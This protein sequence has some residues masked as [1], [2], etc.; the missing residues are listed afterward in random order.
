M[1]QA[2]D[3]ADS[4]SAVSTGRRNMF[5]NGDM[6]IS[7]RYY[8]NAKT[9]VGN[10]EYVIDEWEGYFSNDGAVTIERVSTVPSGEGFKYS[11]KLSVATADTSLSAAQYAVFD[12]HIEAQNLKA[13]RYGT[14]SA[15]TTVLSFWV[16]SSKTGTY[17]LNFYY[18]DTGKQVSKSY[19]IDTADTWEKKTVTVPG[20][21]SN[22]I[23]H[24]H[25][26]GLRLSFWLDAGSNY[27]SGALRSTHTTFAETD[28]AVGQ[29]SWMDS[30]SNDF[31]ITGI[32]YELGN[33]ATEYE[34]QDYS[35]QL[36]RAQ[37]YFFSYGY[38]PY[39]NDTDGQTNFG[40]GMLYSDT[41]IHT[42]IIHPVNMRIE[43][44]L[45]FNTGTNYFIGYTDGTSDSFDSFTHE[46]TTSNVSSTE[47]YTVS[48]NG[49]SLAGKSGDGALV[50]LTKDLGYYG[51]SDH[52][53]IGFSAEL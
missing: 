48:G 22:S 40:M 20:N 26:M 11:M 28:R 17:C 23:T 50:R 36:A 16:R 7:Q 8:D 47:L 29:T 6:T 37:R 32:Q 2:R 14:A 15:K 49:F 35:E 41:Q 12:A 45:V 13:L 31:Y 51:Q 10:G 46:A 3:F 53:F 21:T 38:D 34:F 43:P 27:T 30:T 24:D 42:D 9:S 1:S 18:P 5:Y 39:D 19:T 52:G 33:V 25:G 44:S 4:F